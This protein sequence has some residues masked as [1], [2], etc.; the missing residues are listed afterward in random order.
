[1]Q[2]HKNNIGLLRLVFAGLVVVGHAPEQIDGN[3]T[4]DPLIMLFHTLS[5]GELCVDAFF[6]VSG[7][8]IARSALRT[9][10]LGGFI[11]RR[12]LRVY[13]AYLVAF[14]ICIFGIGPFVYANP[15]EHIPQMLARAA[16]LLGPTTYSGELPGIPYPVLDGAMWTI[17]HE[18]RCYL[19]IAALAAAGLLSR[20][21]LVLGLTLAL[22]SATIAFSAGRLH[23]ALN[24]AAVPKVVSFFLPGGLWQT[25]R[26]TSVFMVGSVGHLFEGRVARITGP[27][28]AVSLA[29]GIALLFQPYAAEIGLSV[30][31]GV[32][33]YWLAMGA[34]LGW[35]QRVNDRWDISYGT[36]LYGWPIATVILYFNRGF[37][38]AELIAISLPLS[39]LAGT[40]SWWGLEKWTK[41]L[42]P[43]ESF[44]NRRPPDM[45]SAPTSAPAPS[46]RSG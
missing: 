33:L 43:S 8:L 11:E 3:R 15:L 14:A 1:M 4:R 20:R 30:F 5:L 28:A 35:L 10:T 12:M 6:L 38:P 16:F 31:G 21:W 19:I 2:Q 46:S 39:L 40:A 13:P 36:Y 23:T 25:L 44:R 24:H 18:F 37:N 42:R 7:Y 45:P 41:D 9:S 34:R 27:V 26:L 22:C 29:T 32:A 17:A